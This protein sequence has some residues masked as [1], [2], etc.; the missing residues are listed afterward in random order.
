MYYV[1]LRNLLIS[2]M[3]VLPKK[4]NTG[5]FT[6]TSKACKSKPSIKT[7]RKEKTQKFIDVNVEKTT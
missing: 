7:I 3:K 5:I 4:T 1:K 6:H 2:D